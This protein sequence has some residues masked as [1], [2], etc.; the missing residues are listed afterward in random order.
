LNESRYH[1]MALSMLDVP[2][3]NKD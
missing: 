1:I 2:K 3:P